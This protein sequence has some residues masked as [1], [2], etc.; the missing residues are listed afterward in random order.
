MHRVSLKSE[1]DRLALGNRSGHSRIPGS[2]AV[3]VAVLSVVLLVGAASSAAATAPSSWSVS[4]TQNK[5]S[6]DALSGVSCTSVNFCVA[7]GSYE[8]SSKVSQNLAE[9]WRGSSWM[10]T[11]T[12]DR[13]TG[14]NSLTGVSC[15]STTDCVAVGDG[16]G[17]TYPLGTVLRFNG[18]KWWISATL[19]YVHGEYFLN[20]VSCPNRDYCVAVG[21]ASNDGGIQSSIFVWNGTKWKQQ[22]NSKT[23]GLKLVG[24]SCTSSSFCAAVGNE[25]P[26]DG[27]PEGVILVFNGRTWSQSATLGESRGSYTM[28]GVSCSRSQFC[29][30]VGYFGN[31]S[32]EFPVIDTWNGS[33]WVGG[34]TGMF[35]SS[36]LYGVSCTS[37]TSCAASGNTLDASDDTFRTFI[38]YGSGTSWAQEA[39]PDVGTGANQLQGASCINANDCVA[40]GYYAKSSENQTLALSSGL[41]AGR[42]KTESPGRPRNS[43]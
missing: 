15:T 11:S 23:G 42:G 43:P 25:V 21:Y 12:P 14:D 27:Y 3:C 30:A 37:T 34:D 36:E 19:S 2:I 16:Y 22:S 20:S 33:S 1:K 26:T 10:I 32:G 17:K 39:T 8:N 6:N 4:A 18:T 28:T 7:V 38:E 29:E 40:V 9:V 13:G 24:V 31:D 5:T 35:H 41:R